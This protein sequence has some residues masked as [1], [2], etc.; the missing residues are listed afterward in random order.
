MG[1]EDQAYKDG[2]SLILFNSGGEADVGVV[3]GCWDFF[4]DVNEVG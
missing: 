1:L 3:D 4:S 2:V